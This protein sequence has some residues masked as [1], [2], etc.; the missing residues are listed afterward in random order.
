MDNAI[1]IPALTEPKEAVFRILE[2]SLLEE[3]VGQ[4]E[5]LPANPREILSAK[6]ELLKQNIQQHPE[7][8][9]YNMLKVFPIDNGHFI[10]IGGNMRYRALRELG[11]A[12]VPCAIIDPQTSV[13]S[14]KAYT[15]LD[16]SGFGKWEWSMLAN[17]WEA[18]QLSSWGVDLPVMESEIDTD[19][20]LDSIEN[21]ADKEKGEKL[22]VTIPEELTEA[23]GEIKSAIEEIL[24]SY[25]GCKVK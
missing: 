18:A 5:G 8:L 22:T 11:F 10:V 15:I 12:K 25:D 14:L 2:L 21:H 17:E 23:K 7:F 19:E 3:N 1:S 9:R 4:L 24:A 20:F 6:Y 16:N 13:E